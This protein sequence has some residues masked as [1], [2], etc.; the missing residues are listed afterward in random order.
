[1]QKWVLRIIQKIIFFLSKAYLEDD[2]GEK[3]GYIMDQ[4][5]AKSINYIFDLS[6]DK[7]ILF[8]KDGL[9]VDKKNEDKYRF[10]L[11]RI[12]DLRDKVEKD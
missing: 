1:M 7:K 2:K 5:T 3:V 4:W 12:Q 9:Q 11:D 10:F 6:G 8:T